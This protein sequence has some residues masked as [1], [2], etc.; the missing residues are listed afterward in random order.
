MCVLGVGIT[1]DETQQQ[2]PPDKIRV[3]KTIIITEDPDWNNRRPRLEQQKTQTKRQK[4]KD[5]D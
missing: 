1:P 3:T 4:T 2:A 5:P